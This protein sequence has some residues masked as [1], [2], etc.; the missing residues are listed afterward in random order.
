MKN[1]CFTIA[2]ISKCGGSERV[3]TTIANALCEKGYN[4]HIL[5][6]ETLKSPFFPCDPRIKVGR[7]LTNAFERRLRYKKWYRTW[8]CRRYF[9]QNKI[10][11]V[12]D[13]DTSLSRYSIPATQGTDIKVVSWDQFNY[14]FC[15]SRPGHLEVLKLIEQHANKLVLLTDSDRATYLEKT[16]LKPEFIKR[17]YNP[18]SFEESE[19]VERK[20]KKVLAIGRIVPQKGFDLLLRSWQI[21]ERESDDWQLEIVC[22]SGDYNIL[23]QQAEAMGLKKVSC[24]P[25]TNDV[26]SKYA[27]SGIYALSSRYEGFGLVLTEASTMGLPMVSYNCKVGPNE[28]IHDG[29]NGF[30]VEPENVELFAEKLIYLI[31]HEDVRLSMGKHAFETSKRFSID[32]IVLQWIELIENL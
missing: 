25:P 9:L 12:I 7:M 11:V 20:E 19:H 5:T 18:L 23:Q 29:E 32:N 31:K 10:D 2:D 16:Y 30:L 24:T 17:I 14:D 8:K 21:V 27:E 22:G 15:I 28:I 3:C 26:K 1:I 4:I 6:G 13:V